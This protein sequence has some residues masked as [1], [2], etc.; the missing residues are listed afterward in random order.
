[1]SE[2]GAS[3]EHD[4]PMT[5]LSTD[6]VNAGPMLVF[7]DGTETELLKFCEKAFV[8]PESARV[9]SKALINAFDDNGLWLASLIQPAHLV[10]ELRQ[11][12]NLL[13]TLIVTQW[14]RQGETHKLTRLG[15]A[16]LDARPPLESHEGGQMMAVLAGLLG[17][18]RPQ[19]A[20]RLLEACRHLLRDSVDHRLIQDA[21]EW[22]AVGRILEKLHPEDRIFWN[23]RLREPDGGWEWESAEARA[24]LR[25]LVP[26]LPNDDETDVS[27][28]H[29]VVPGCWW[30][31][32]RDGT[33]QSASPGA[34]KASPS[35][36]PAAR[37]A[38]A[39]RSA[40]FSQ[41]LFSGLAAAG[42]TVGG[43]WFAGMLSTGSKQA[44]LVV[45]RGPTTS[46]APEMK[47]PVVQTP[48]LEPAAPQAQP[49]FTPPTAPVVVQ[50]PEPGKATSTPASS[51]PEVAE[52]ASEVSDSL[53]RLQALLG[54][55][56][57]AK[58]VAPSTPTASAPSTE[59][60]EVR[61]P[62]VQTAGTAPAQPTQAVSLEALAASSGPSKP[63]ARKLYAEHFATTHAHLKRVHTLAR[64]GT[65]RESESLIQGRSA[66]V[67][68]G[69]PEHVDLIRWLVLDPPERPEIR[70]TVTKLALR[71]IPPDELVH[72]LEL[73]Q[74]PG[75]PN[76]EEARQCADWLL[77]L[78]EAMLSPAQ[79]QKLKWLTVA[80]RP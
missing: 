51:S 75:S 47:A 14:T 74:Y 57:A 48:V 1:M 12:C 37:L 79:Q 30:D 20:Q 80:N 69:S 52:K 45:D 60:A 54:P 73:C 50:A 68:Y 11:S 49:V 58:T 34:P 56:A 23:R 76:Q 65:P 38:D 70:T 63:S 18:L 9:G 4:D 67:A 35:P 77:T 62:I 29:D 28:F 13:T 32:V 46:A 21:K 17:I 26:L 27:K 19:R 72:M 66:S 33:L 24:A 78:N 53:R 25:K 8:D 43:L 7:G 36:T 42:I 40:S 15:E 44:P 61:K 55:D 16:L 10:A 64:D 2:S 3:P 71:V 59:P 31:L 5:E 6:G 41:G 39:P 22:T